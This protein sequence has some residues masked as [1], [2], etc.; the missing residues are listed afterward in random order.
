MYVCV[1]GVSSRELTEIAEVD[2]P[3]VAISPMGALSS[4]L[5]A[6]LNGITSL[7]NNSN[8]SCSGGGGSSSSNNQLPPSNLPSSAFLHSSQSANGSMLIAPQH[9]LQVRVF[10]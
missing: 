6:P 9:H 8:S 4:P 3:R 2:E 1:G 5:S 7:G 10:H